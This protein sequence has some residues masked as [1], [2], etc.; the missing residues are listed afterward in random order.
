[1]TFEGTGTGESGAGWNPG[2]R[3]R[4]LL[5]GTAGSLGDIRFVL[6]TLPAKARGQVFVEVG[7]ADEIETLDAP[8]RF[9]ICWLLRD[10]GQQLQRSV[11]AWLSEMLPVSGTEEHSVYA[12]IASEGAPRV[13]SSD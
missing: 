7:S 13:L 3:D 12:W 5:A 2:I 6:A 1:M 9:A 11:D 10:R 4:I 8:P